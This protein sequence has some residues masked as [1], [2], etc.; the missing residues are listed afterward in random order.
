MKV[1][2]ILRLCFVLTAVVSLT[3]GIGCSG[4]PPE[5]NLPPEKPATAE[6]LKKADDQLKEAMKNMGKPK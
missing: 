4:T 3:S 5:G 1:R 6:D 2:D